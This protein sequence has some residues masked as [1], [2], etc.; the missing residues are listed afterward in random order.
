MRRIACLLALLLLANR[1][2]AACT[3]CGGGP[4]S[5]QT[6]REHFRQA[7]FV[8]HGKLKNPKFDPNG[9]GGTTEFHVERVLKADPAI[10]NRKVLL[11]PKYLP[12][13]GDTPPDYLIFCAVVDGKPDPV[14]GVPVAAGVVDYLLGAAK[15]DKQDAVKRLGYFFARLDAVEPA[16]AADAFVEF[17]KASDAELVKAR[18]VLDPAKLRKLLTARDTPSERVGVFA[19]MLGLCGTKTDA[20]LFAKLLDAQPPPERVRENLGGFL[21]ALT[22]LDADAGWGRTQAILTDAKR[23]FDQ[24]LAAVGT[25]RF[26]QATRAVE[27]KP[28]VLKCYRGLLAH[29]DLADVAIDDL[30]RWGWWDLTADVL[31]QFNRPTHAAPVLRRGIVRYALRCPADEAKR[32]VAAVRAKDPKLVAGVEETLKLYESP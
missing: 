15:F 18:A 8:A 26:F 1:P 31:K 4:A 24:R 7:K 27:A 20:D 23:P 12:V 9:G 10:G 6:L 14:H 32:F 28:W 17:A 29:G 3:F 11:L 22:L 2:A 30:R 19:L 21:A 16:V 5:R 25:V 13:I